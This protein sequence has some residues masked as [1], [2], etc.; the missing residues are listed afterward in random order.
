MIATTFISDN[1]NG[2]M[3]NS[4]QATNA[5]ELGTAVLCAV[6]LLVIMVLAL[7]G[8]L[9]VLFIIAKHSQLRTVVNAFITSL[10]ISDVLTVLTCMTESLVTIIGGDWI[11]GRTMC[12][13]NGTLN[14]A[15]S[16]ASTLSVMLIAIDRFYAI[17][18]RPNGR[19]T[20]RTAAISL[21]LAWIQSFF[22]AFPWYVLMP[23]VKANSLYFI[24]NHYHCMYIFDTQLSYSG[25]A[26]S[27][28]VIT[29]CYIVPFIVMIYCSVNVLKTVR[30]N[31][32][33]I[34]PASAHVS[35]LLFVAEM[36]TANTV[37]IMVLV[38]VICKG[39]YCV[40][41]IVSVCLKSELTFSMDTISLWLSWT[42]CAINPIIYANRNPHV[43]GIIK[44]CR[45]RHNKDSDQLTNGR[46]HI[47]PSKIPRSRKSIYEISDPI[48]K[49]ERQD[50]IVSDI[51]LTRNNKRLN[52]LTS[53]TLSTRTD[54]TSLRSNSICSER[55]CPNTRNSRR[56]SQLLVK[57]MLNN[58]RR[59]SSVMSESD[60][61][62]R[63]KNPPCLI[64]QTLPTDVDGETGP[65]SGRIT[66][67]TQTTV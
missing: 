50:S 9:A 43:A 49:S 34:R 15:F 5:N 41:A 36:R 20:S 56:N 48:V 42:N 17:V 53:D 38:F 51:F 58:S 30:A 13:L 54:V 28:I 18:K 32:F 33:K 6:S 3:I 66:T 37:V 64:F 24:Q 19:I 57:T 26:F 47:S 31:D 46:V 7:F 2:T 39:C 27:I 55:I 11:L 59:N 12:V 60:V 1:I 67:D 25:V 23:N 62:E 8:N 10:S 29:V 14:S 40:M 61:A 35:Q 16:I 65:Q 21:T 22:F 44:C 45:Q 63:R 4:W 52:S